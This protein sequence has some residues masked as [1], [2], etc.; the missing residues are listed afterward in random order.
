MIDKPALTNIDELREAVKQIRSRNQSLGS[1]LE[2][3]AIDEI[4]ALFASYTEKQNS[5]S[6]SERFDYE[7]L[8]KLETQ[9]IEQYRQMRGVPALT[10]EAVVSFIN[11]LSPW[12]LAT[13]GIEVLKVYTEKRE[14][15]ARM[16]E[17]LTIAAVTELKKPPSKYVR[18]VYLPLDYI[19]KRIAELQGGQPN[20]GK[21]NAS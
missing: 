2:S 6:A 16:D 3:P 18:N 19:K 9:G 7:R 15:E 4:M 17:W 1:L 21:D 13:T 12:N 20:K 11:Q 14:R 5:L 8:K 10:P